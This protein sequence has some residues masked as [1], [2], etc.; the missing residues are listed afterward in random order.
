MPVFLFLIRCVVV[1]WKEWNK[2]QLRLSRCVAKAERSE[3]SHVDC[4]E[5]LILAFQDQ[6]VRLKTVAERYV[7][8]LLSVSLLLLHEQLT[9]SSQTVTDA[10][11]EY[12]TFAVWLL[13]G[14]ALLTCVVVVA[15]GYQKTAR[16]AERGLRALAGLGATLD[17]EVLKRIAEM[18]SKL[19]WDQSPG[20]F[21]FSVAKS[22]TISIPLLLA[23]IA[24][25]LHLHNDGW[26]RIFVPRTLG[27]FFQNVFK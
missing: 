23:V 1:D 14:P 8:V 4:F 2:G 20:T 6:V 7:P 24:Y 9:P 11:I 18:R 16:K 27:E 25:V 12:G 26:F 21:I 13:L 3:E 17:S 15:F 5:G 22:A 10:A 19:I